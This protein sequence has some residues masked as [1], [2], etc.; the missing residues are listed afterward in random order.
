[1]QPMLFKPILV[2]VFEEEG[3]KEESMEEPVGK[4]PSYGISEGSFRED[5]NYK[6]TF[7][8]VKDDQTFTSTCSTRNVPSK[9]ESK[10]NSMSFC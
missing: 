7:K 6:D 9:N 5:V 8:I 3:N 1:M 10:T 4:L 2:A